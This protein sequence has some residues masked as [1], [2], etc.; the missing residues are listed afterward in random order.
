MPLS[1]PAETLKAAHL[2][3]IGAPVSAMWELLPGGRTLFT[4]EPAIEALEVNELGEPLVD[5]YGTPWGQ[6]LTAGDTDALNVTGTTHPSISLCP[7]PTSSEG[8]GY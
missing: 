1:V 7:S 4:V 6:V 2:S 3:D 5:L 8:A